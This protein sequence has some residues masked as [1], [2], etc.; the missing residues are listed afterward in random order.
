MNALPKGKTVAGGF[1]S[2]R[3][4]NSDFCEAEDSE[5]FSSLEDSHA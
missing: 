2:E 3:E 1:L 5:N 4:A